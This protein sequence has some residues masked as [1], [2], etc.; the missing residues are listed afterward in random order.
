M[1][2]LVQENTALIAGFYCLYLIFNKNTR[3]RGFIGT[4][5]SFGYFYLVVN[6]LIPRVS[7]YGFYLFSGIYGSPL[8][9]SIGQIFIS[10]LLNPLLF[11]KTLFSPTNIVYLR[12]LLMPLP[13]ALLSPLTLLSALVALAQN[14]LSSSSLLKTHLLHYESGFVPFAYLAAILGASKIMVHRKLLYLGLL[15]M[16]LSVSFGYKLFTPLKLNPSLILYESKNF[17]N[18]EIDKLTSQIPQSSSVSTQDYLSAKLASR[19]RLYMFP[20]YADQVDYVLIA[21]T[22]DVW[23]LKVEEQNMYLAKLKTTRPVI[24]ETPKFILFGR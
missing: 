15:V 18:D 21:K 19:P 24:R 6:V 13:V 9:G 22:S 10:S 4:A 7:P 11:L 23:P 12:D 2:W 1:F 17:K 16:A 3:K 5:L 20:V 14:L 8:G